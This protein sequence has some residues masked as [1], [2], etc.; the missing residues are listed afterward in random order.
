MHKFLYPG[1]DGELV[2]PSQST[3]EPVATLQAV[4]GDLGE[5]A[6]RA[7]LPPEDARWAD[8]TRSPRGT[9]EARENWRPQEARAMFG[10]LGGGVR[11]PQSRRASGA[12]HDLR[13][14]EW[15]PAKRARTY[16]LPK[17]PPPSAA[18]ARPWAGAWCTFPTASN[19]TFPR[20]SP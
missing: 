16:V 20:R 5:G 3:Q 4:P 8:D 18:P 12:S 11:G 6:D 10:P 19:P 15:A 13:Y 9:Q 1:G 17:P 7:D 14:D 2:P